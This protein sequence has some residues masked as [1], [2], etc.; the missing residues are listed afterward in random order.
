MLKRSKMW[1]SFLC[2]GVFNNDPHPENVSDFISSILFAFNN[3][4]K[5]K[6]DS[7]HLP[8]RNQSQ[9]CFNLF[10][11]IVYLSELWAYACHARIRPVLMFFPAN[12]VDLPGEENLTDSWFTQCLDCSIITAAGTKSTAI[13]PHCLAFLHECFADDSLSLLSL[14]LH[15]LHISI[16]T[17]SFTMSNI[18]LQLCMFNLRFPCSH[19]YKHTCRKEVDN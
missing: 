2:V 8:D 9:S 4:K 7:C 13:V 17:G 12:S 3:L 6:K 18:E 19:K 15:S 14:A 5:E 11:S 10:R 16:L 1:F